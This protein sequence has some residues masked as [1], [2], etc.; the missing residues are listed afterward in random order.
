VVAELIQNTADWG[1]IQGALDE[2]RVCHEETANFFSGIF[3]EL[4]RL[5]E[6]IASQEQQMAKQAVVEQ[7]ELA[8]MQTAAK[9]HWEELRMQLEEDR[10]A[11][12]RSEQVVQEQIGQLRGIAVDLTSAQN[13]LRS[14]CGELARRREELATARTPTAVDSPEDKAGINDK[15]RDLEQQQSLLE[16]ER[17]VLENELETVRRHAA[18]MADSL[19]EQK[20]LAAQ[21]QNQW[22]E[23]LRQMRMILE[24]LTEQFAASR[25]PSE[26]A[27]QAG[28]APRVS[29]VASSD[30][31]LESVLAQFE[32]LQQD[33]LRRRAQEAEAARKKQ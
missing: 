3:D 16:K 26:S 15:I 28:L 7:D 33:R 27:A 4:D 25:Q 17:A 20:R 12:R 23:D 29:A 32:I 10:G 5:C 14:A 18:E 21:Q 13:E 8:V 31:V 1:Q 11:L 6:S 19:A 24:N 2:I 30:P 9:D 22:T